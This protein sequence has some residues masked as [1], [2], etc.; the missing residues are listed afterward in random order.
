MFF[1][2]I[3]DKVKAVKKIPDRLDIITKRA[4]RPLAGQ[5]S[6]LNR[7]QLDSGIKA[8]GSFLPDYSNRSVAEF[9]KRPGRMTLRDTGDF[10]DSIKPDF[11]QAEFVLDASDSKTDMLQDAYGDEIIGLTDK[12]VFEIGTEAIGQI[13]YELK[14]EL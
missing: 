6:E 14:K 4:L 3:R 10:Q 8:D 11:L 2:A 1:E 12:S 13:Q 7:E 5:I 9:G